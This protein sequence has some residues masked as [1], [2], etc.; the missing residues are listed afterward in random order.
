MTA[1]LLS[2]FG[3]ALVECPETSGGLAYFLVNKLPVEN[4]SQAVSDQMIA[5]RQLFQSSI[6]SAVLSVIF[7]NGGTIHEE[8]VWKFLTRLRLDVSPKS[9]RL[10]STGISI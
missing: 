10:I 5:R 8:E 6:L 4:L 7:M 2:T 9:K 1:V 3:I